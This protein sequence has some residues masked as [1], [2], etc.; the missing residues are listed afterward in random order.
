MAKANTMASEYTF[1]TKSNDPSSHLLTKLTMKQ[2]SLGS[3]WLPTS[4][5]QFPGGNPAFN[6]IMCDTDIDSVLSYCG[7]IYECEHWVQ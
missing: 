4:A 5:E 3:G 1:M 2:D 6:V 7:S